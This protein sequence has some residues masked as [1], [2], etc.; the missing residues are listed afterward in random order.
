MK[1]SKFNFI[2]E[3][4]NE[5]IIYNFLTTSF[6]VLDRRNFDLYQKGQYE[7]VEQNEVLIKAGILVEDGL[8]EEK[9]YRQIISDAQNKQKELFDEITIFTTTACNA[10]C[11]YC[12]EHNLTPISL[13]R[14]MMDAVIKFITNNYD[15]NKVTLRWF[16]G[17]PLVN[18]NVIDIICDELQKKSIEF[19]SKMITNGFLFDDATI[20]RAKTNWKLEALQIT[21]DGLYEDY[22]KIKNYKGDI[23]NSFA[24]VIDNVQKLIVQKILVSIRINYDVDDTSCA[25][26]LIDF[27]STHFE[28]KKY[29]SVSCAAVREAGKPSLASFNSSNSPQL[30]LLQ[31]L[32]EHGFVKN[33]ANI[34]PRPKVFPCEANV[35]RRYFIY[36]N[37]NIYKC[38]H[39]I[40]DDFFDPVGNIL[41]EKFNNEI[42]EQWSKVEI[43]EKCGC[44]RIFPIC[45][46]GCRSLRKQNLVPDSEC[47][48]YKNSFDGL[49]KLYYKFYKEEKNN[50]STKNG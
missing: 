1:S 11:Y 27:L 36:P 30:E 2:V 23:K 10:R 40:S 43:P 49:L 37:G 7:C 4:D 13:D 5:N 42:L 3:N 19:T 20:Q 26:K 47:N 14:Q 44:C 28:D 25:K 34:L 32:Y 21:L 41:A 38:Q 50:G 33:I 39:T 16:G 17:E 18:V 22:D 48:K 15:G 8:D 9:Y 45:Q 12:Y 46:G 29:L 24:K 35:P 31:Y 6:I